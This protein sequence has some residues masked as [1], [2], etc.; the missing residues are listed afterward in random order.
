[1]DDEMGGEMGVEMDFEKG[2][3]KARTWVAGRKMP[4]SP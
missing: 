2:S 1:M 4:S 3:A